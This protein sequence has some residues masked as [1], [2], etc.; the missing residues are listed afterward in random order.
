MIPNLK[1]IFDCNPVNPS[2]CP[3][4]IPRASGATNFTDLAT[5]L[6]G[7]LNIAFYIG[8]FMAFYWLVWGAFQYILAKGDKEGLA[9][10]RARITWA[11]VGLMVILT[12]YLIATFAAQILPV[13][14]A[15][16]EAPRP[17]PEGVPF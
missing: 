3:S 13:R 11:I 12:A 5:F 1:D 17:T 16:G 2:G 6:S 4:P 15:P 9:K 8:A 14:P 7:L 10:A